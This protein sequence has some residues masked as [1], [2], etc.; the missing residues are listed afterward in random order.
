MAHEKSVIKG[1]KEK[2]SS[3]MVFMFVWCSVNLKWIFIR[4]PF[5]LKLQQVL[6]T[7]EYTPN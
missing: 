1:I 3:S 7:L 2:K 4:N 5:K 6:K